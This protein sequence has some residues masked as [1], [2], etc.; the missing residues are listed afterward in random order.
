M[1]ID[2]YAISGLGGWEAVCSEDGKIEALAYRPGGLPVMG[3]KRLHPTEEAAGEA[4]SEWYLPSLKS[5][6]K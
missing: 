1:N 3:D 4:N 2:Q 5:E 6:D